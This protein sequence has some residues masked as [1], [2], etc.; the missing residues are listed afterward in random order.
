MDSQ[1]QELKA[2]VEAKIKLMQA[3]ILELKADSSEKSREQ[4]E[5]LERELD[6]VRTQISEGYK[7]LKRQTLDKL[8]QWLKD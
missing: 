4:A 3:R 6:D 1:Q 7:D 5:R 8:N 2:R